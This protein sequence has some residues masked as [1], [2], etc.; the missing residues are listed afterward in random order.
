MVISERRSIEA[1]PDVEWHSAG[2]IVEAFLKHRKRA[3]GEWIRRCVL[4]KSR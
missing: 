1:D 3:H 4:P 2:R